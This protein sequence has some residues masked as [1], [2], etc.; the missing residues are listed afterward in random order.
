ME[1]KD[2]V[3]GWLGATWM[4]EPVAGYARLAEGVVGDVIA[5][6]T[7][8]LPEGLGG[9]DS[10]PVT[11]CFL[12]Y[13]PARSSVD[14]IVRVDEFRPSR[15]LENTVEVGDDFEQEIHNSSPDV[16]FQHLID[17]SPDLG[18][19]SL[20]PEQAQEMCWR[21]Y[22]EDKSPPPLEHLWRPLETFED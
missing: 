3:S 14:Y 20:T 8:N 21:P 6:F 19:F 12:R 16:I 11:I 10:C 1:N 15:S 18:I 4:D 17:A 7:L 13:D 22:V 5:L 2:W 9:T